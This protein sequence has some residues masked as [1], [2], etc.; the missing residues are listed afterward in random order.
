MRHSRQR[1]TGAA[2][3]YNCRVNA[4]PPIFS[5][6][7]DGIAGLE[8]LPEGVQVLALD[9]GQWPETEARRSWR[10]GAA[11]GQILLS[12]K[13]PN[14]LRDD[15]GEVSLDC[16]GSDIWRALRL[17]IPESLS[18]L[19]VLEALDS[20]AASRFSIEPEANYPVRLPTEHP[21]YEADRARRLTHLLR[22]A[23]EN[24]EARRELLIAA[25]ELLVQSHF[26][27]AHRCGIASES[28]DSLVQMAREAGPKSGIYGAR[29]VGEAS[30]GL[31]LILC[32][33]GENTRAILQGLRE[34]YVSGHFS[35]RKRP[36]VLRPKLP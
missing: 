8:T 15:D 1:E 24:P 10:L 29:L 22:A 3:R 26:S 28:A 9:T 17:Q 33:S 35:T 30:G 6:A 20:S 31:V 13:I 4:P 18:G 5:P 19:Q 7:P 34:D 12:R 23:I 27:L 16:V 36:Q 2:A 11:V 21:I 32:D 25:G 14:A